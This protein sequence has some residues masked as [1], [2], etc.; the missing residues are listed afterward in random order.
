MVVPPRAAGFPGGP[1]MPAS[2][3]QTP[4]YVPVSETL[5]FVIN[6]RAIKYR[7]LVV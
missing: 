7:L 1:R 5:R 4:R 2:M 3:D 6:N